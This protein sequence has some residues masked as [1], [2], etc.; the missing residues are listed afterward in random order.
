MANELNDYLDQL[1]ETFLKTNDELSNKSNEILELYRSI[2]IPEDV[3]HDVIPEDVPHDVIPE[4][5]IPEVST[6]VPSKKVPP[7]GVN[8]TAPKKKVNMV[9]K[10]IGIKDTNVQTITKEINMVLKDDINIDINKGVY[11]ELELNEIMCNKIK[12]Q[13]DESK[14][15]NSYI[16]YFFYILM[17]YIIKPI[18]D[19]NKITPIIKNNNKQLKVYIDYPFDSINQNYVTIKKQFTDIYDFITKFLMNG[20]EAL[21][22]EQTR[23]T[24][25]EQFTA[26]LRTIQQFRFT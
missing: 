1:N 20:P 9:Q 17:K 19:N 4:D 8:Q 15:L 7:K 14:K 3:L 21:Q 26:L 5:V 12:E 6:N 22:L 25:D 23:T 24:T 18:I 16:Y 10:F 2:V 11:P 13:T